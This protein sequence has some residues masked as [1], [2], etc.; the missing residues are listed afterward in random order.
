MYIYFIDAKIDADNNKIWNQFYIAKCVCLGNTDKIMK[1]R[2]DNIYT[3][4][5]SFQR[6]VIQ[7]PVLLF[8]LCTTKTQKPHLSF[9]YR[10]LLQVQNKSC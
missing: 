5:N 1:E 2:N 9:C 8:S 4:L 7:E 3:A 10:Q 6:I